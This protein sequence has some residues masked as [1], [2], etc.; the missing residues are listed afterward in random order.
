LGVDIVIES[1]GV[2][3]DAEKAQAHIDGG[4]AKKVIISA[5]AKGANTIVM[6]VNEC[7]YNPAQHYVLS[8]ASCTTN[9]LAPLAKAIHAHFRITAGFMT[10]V[11]SYTNEQR[12]ADQWH[13]DIRRARAAATNIIPTS[14]GAALAIGLVLPEL[15]GKLDGVALRVPTST[16][17]IVDLVCDVEEPLV[18]DPADKKARQKAIAEVNK[19]LKAAAE[20]KY[21]VYSEEE[22][23]S[24]DLIGNSASSIVDAKLTNVIGANTLKVFS[25]YDN[26]WGYSCRLAELA[27]Y[28]ADRL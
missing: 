24:S 15:D 21:L 20:G 18:S 12:L 13:L 26:E 27:K 23:V 9:C 7:T 11:H 16:V 5:P 1:T 17:S 14:T 28:V 25:W 10:T 3:N 2:F 22:L 19:A 8:N 4:K 6:G